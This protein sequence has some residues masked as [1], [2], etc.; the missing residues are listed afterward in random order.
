MHVVTLLISVQIEVPGI[1]RR[2]LLL[3]PSA[4]H[5]VWRENSYDTSFGNPDTK[6]P[7]S[8]CKTPV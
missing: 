1:L 4:E 6:C 2:K 7:L 3:Q 5:L 8:I